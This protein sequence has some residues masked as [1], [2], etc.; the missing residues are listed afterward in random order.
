MLYN[1]YV[2]PHF[3]YRNTVRSNT[4]S[5]NIDKISKLQ[6]RACKLILSQD[7]TDIQEALERLYMCILSFDQ[8]IFLNKSNED[9]KDQETVQSSTTP[10]P[11][12]H[13]GN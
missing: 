1:A 5:G 9:G 7:C 6:R 10:D 13:M 3:E 11:G 12:Y 8:I 2:K 4:S